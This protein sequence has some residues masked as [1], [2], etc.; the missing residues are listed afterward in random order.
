[1]VKINMAG[2]LG[3]ALHAVG[4]KNLSTLHS[5]INIQTETK[6]F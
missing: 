1:M 6:L 2:L 4:A 3:E 5:K